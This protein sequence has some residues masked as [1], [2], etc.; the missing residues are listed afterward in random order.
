M[1]QP[2]SCEA[3]RT[4]WPRRPIAICCIWSGT[5]TS[6]RLASGI[7]HHLADLGRRQG[8]DHE[9]GVIGRPGNDV[10]LLAAELLHH[11]LDAA[12]A[13]ADAGADRVDAAVLGDHRDLGPAARVAGA[14]LDLDDAVVDLRH[15]LLEQLL[16]EAGM[17]A[18]EEDLR[19]AQLVA[20]VVEK[21]PDAIL[22]AEQL[23]R[24]QIV[25]ADDRLGPAE[26]DQRVAVLDPLDLADH[27]LADP[28]LELVVLPL[29][30]GLAHPLDDDLLGALRGDAAEVDRRQGIQDV[31]ADLGRGVAHLRVLEPDLAGIV[32]DRVG[33]LEL[34]IE[35]MLAGAPVDLGH[36]LVL[37]A[38]GAACG[39]LVGLLHGLEHLVDRDALLLRHGLDDA[40]HFRA[41]EA[42]THVHRR[43]SLPTTSARL[44]AGP[45][46][47][48][49]RQ[50]ELGLLYRRE[51]DPDCGTRLLDH[52]LVV[53]QP[54]HDA[55]KP[56]AALD[57]GLALDL[58]LEAGEALEIARDGPAAGRA[59]AS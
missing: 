54:A 43:H 11:G 40:Q 29:A 44:T 5:I 8:V 55:A 26:I 16:H 28:V 45:G 22:G 4:F 14:G 32:L 52:D 30:L 34:A 20:D 48:S 24:D 46:K 1:S 3:R 39:G 41:T 38:V 47:Q 13:H 6:I 25:A 19:P 23:A 35:P 9:G 21:R 36:D 18:R 2:V 56:L 49:R 31:V 27:D 57:G 33:D 17:G 42:R 37:G 50:G 59:Q 15:L 7:E 58:G 51:R 53:F 10:D 12:A